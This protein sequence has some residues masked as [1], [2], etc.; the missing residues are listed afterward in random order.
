[1]PLR[2]S[3]PAPSGWVSGTRPLA[4]NVVSTGACS[5]SASEVTSASAPGRRD[6]R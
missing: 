1:V 5:R 4:L 3:T 2:P 6:R